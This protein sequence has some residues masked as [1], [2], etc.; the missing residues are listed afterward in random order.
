MSG[1]ARNRHCAWGRSPPEDPLPTYCLDKSNRDLP[2]RKSMRRWRFSSVSAR[3]FKLCAGVV[4]LTVLFDLPAHPAPAPAFVP[5]PEFKIEDKALADALVAVLTAARAGNYAEAIA[6]ARAA[7]RIENK[8]PHI[9]PLL[10]TMIINYATWA[11]EYQTAISE[12]EKRIAIGEGNTQA[13]L[14]LR[15]Q[16]ALK[17]RE[18]RSSRQTPR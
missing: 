7:E 9:G 15:E 2:A 3:Q 4:A 11:G 12:L 5:V 10:R 14:K 13:N 17:L 1:N 8:P 16:L 6:Q 18:H